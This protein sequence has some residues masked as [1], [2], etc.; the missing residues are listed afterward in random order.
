MSKFE[1]NNTVTSQDIQPEI[2][3]II[4]ILNN[5]I[6]RTAYQRSTNDENKFFIQVSETTLLSND[7]YGDTGGGISNITSGTSVPPL[8]YYVGGSIRLNANRLLEMKTE[9]RNGGKN[10]L[11]Y[12]LLHETLHI[13]GLQRDMWEQYNYLIQYVETSTQDNKFYYVGSNALREYKNYFSNNDFI[14]IPLEDDGGVGTENQHFE[15]GIG[16][17]SSLNRYIN[18]NGSEILHPGLNNEVTTGFL[19][20][21]PDFIPLQLTTIGALQD[22]GF[23]VDY[24]YADNYTNNNNNMICFLKDTNISC[25]VDGVEKEVPIQ[26]IVPGTLVKT[27]KS[28]YIPV[29]II[30]NKNIINP[31]SHV[32]DY[33]GNRVKNQLYILKNENPLILTGCHSLLLDELTPYQKMGME[34]ECDGKTFMTDGKYR[35]MAFLS[36]MEIYD[37]NGPANIWHFS[38][39]REDI[40][41]NYGVYANGVLVE[42]CSRRMMLCYSDMAL[43]IT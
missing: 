20:L 1:V 36:D 38:L 29:D 35:L 10:T 6:I 33:L 31:N 14:G 18:V 19:N 4:D 27:L 25:L 40:T 39:E 3:N 41:M 7:T 28:G 26:N 9:I 11:Y 16:G 15:E 21:A 24:T 22:I 30:G 17:L 12:V 23:E 13:L 2:D 37:Y 8:Y 43:N 42:S 32:K 34:L 5:I